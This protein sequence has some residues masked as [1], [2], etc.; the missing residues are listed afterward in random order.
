VYLGNTTS[1]GARPGVI[2]A[3]IKQEGQHTCQRKP[4]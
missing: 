4:P 2:E 3:A 1:E